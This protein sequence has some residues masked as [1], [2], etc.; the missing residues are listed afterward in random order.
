MVT[1]EQARGIVFDN[2]AHL[3]PAEADFQVATWGW[4]NDSAYQLICG[5]YAMVYPARNA[6][7]RL[8]ISDQ[9]GPFV[10]VDKATGEYAEHYGLTDDGRPFRLDGATP[11]GE[12]TEAP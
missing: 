4:E 7:D 11:I 6:D 9:D 10:T 12:P 2:R 3:Y 1:F 5:P 8:W